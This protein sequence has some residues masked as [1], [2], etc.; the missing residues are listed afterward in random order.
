M[1]VSVSVVVPTLNE[2]AGI[3]PLLEAL[4]GQSYP[5]TQIIIADG[6]STDGTREILADHPTVTVVDN[7][8]R[9]AAAGRNVALQRCTTEWVLFTDGDCRPGPT[10]A[11]ELMVAAADDPTVVGVGGRLT[12]EPGNVFERVC[13]R[14]L[15][16]VIMRHGAGSR[17]VTAKRLDGALVTANCAYRR[18]ILERL[19]GFD[20]RF[21]N[22]GEDIDL[23]FRVLELNAGTLRHTAD[24]VVVGDMPDTLAATV[25]KWRQYGMAS[26]YLN[27]YHYRRAAV[28]VGLYRKSF[29]FMREAATMS[30][31]AR[32]EALI[33]AA[34]LAAHIAGKF[35][36]SVRLRTLNL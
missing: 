28:D 9:H 24:A 35:E 7:P 20:E 33:C 10:W 3:V 23:M 8:R 1:V 25:R 18:D 5:I 11:H 21:S 19:G 13:A 12:A 4:R 26:S 14:M 16:D 15:L 27:K 32:T 29:G 30:G 34:Q 2:A 22:F 31:A 17:P 36:G 6:G